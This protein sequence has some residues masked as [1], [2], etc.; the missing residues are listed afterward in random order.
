MCVE[1]D[2]HD[3]SIL[4]ERKPMAGM[5][6]LT[7]LGRQFHSSQHLIRIRSARNPNEMIEDESTWGER[8]AW[9]SSWS[10]GRCG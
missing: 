6:M 10:A 9:R 5:D 7:V 1:I 2:R 3:I 4:L 8:I